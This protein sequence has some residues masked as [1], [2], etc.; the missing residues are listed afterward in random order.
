MVRHGEH[1]R[2]REQKMQWDR[3]YE[4]VPRVQGILQNLVR[5]Q[6][7]IG[8]KMERKMRNQALKVDQSQSVVLMLQ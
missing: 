2:Q 3:G 8:A 5:L 4:R 1:L 7:R 6:Y